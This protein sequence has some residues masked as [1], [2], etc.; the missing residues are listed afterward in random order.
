[1]VSITMLGYQSPPQWPSDRHQPNCNKRLF[2]VW[3][4]WLPPTQDNWV[5]RWPCNMELDDK[6]TRIHAP[7]ERHVHPAGLAATSRLPPLAPATA[8][9]NPMALGPLCPISLTVPYAPLPPGLYRIS[10][11]VLMEHPPATTEAPRNWQVLGCTRLAA[12]MRR[13]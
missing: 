5:W 12:T 7:N 2:E 13:R 6:T 10:Q 9:G 1:M 4:Q 11:A 8:S 3:A